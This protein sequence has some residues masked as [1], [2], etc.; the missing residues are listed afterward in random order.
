[1]F[2]HVLARVEQKFEQ[3]LRGARKRRPA[4]H[5][6]RGKERVL[7]QQEFVFGGARA[8]TGDAR[9]AVFELQDESKFQDQAEKCGLELR[10]VF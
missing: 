5:H 10:L 2:V 9:A 3:L 1:M 6:R 4:A 7:R 8:E